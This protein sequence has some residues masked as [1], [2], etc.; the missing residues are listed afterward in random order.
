MKDAVAI[1]SLA[2][3]LGLNLW[4]WATEFSIERRFWYSLP[5]GALGFGGFF[6][7]LSWRS[8]A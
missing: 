2:V 6:A 3:W 4:L 1:V 7:Y 5:L 8:R